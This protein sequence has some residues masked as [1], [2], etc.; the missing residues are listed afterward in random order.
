MNDKIVI[1]L[2]S[3]QCSDLRQMNHQPLHFIPRTSSLDLNMQCKIINK[4]S[5]Y[6]L[7]NIKNTCQPNNGSLK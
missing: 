2:A 7:N 5:E 6:D 1:G 4:L 3:T